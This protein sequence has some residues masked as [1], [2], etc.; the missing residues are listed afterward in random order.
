MRAWWAKSAIWITLLLALLV[1]DDCWADVSYVNTRTNV[2]TTAVNNIAIVPPV[3]SAAG[4]LLITHIAVRSSVTVTTPSGWSVLLGPTTN[5][6]ARYYVFYRFIP[7]GGLGS[8]TFTFSGNSRTVAGMIALRSADTVNP[9]SAFGVAS[10]TGTTATAPTRPVANDG[11]YVL[12]L[13]AGADGDTAFV[14]ASPSSSPAWSFNSTGGTANGIAG[15]ALYRAANTG[16]SG[17]TATSY[18]NNA[19]LAATL[20]ISPSSQVCFSDSFNRSSGLGSD[21]ATSSSNGSFGVPVI[22]NNR[23]RMTDASGNVATAATLQRLFPADGNFVQLSFLLHDYG[24]NGADGIAVI[25]SDATVTPQ[26]GGYGGS[27]GY[28]QLTATSK[29]GFA[30][31]WLGVGLDEYGNFL[32]TG[33]GRGNGSGTPAASC[34]NNSTLRPDSVSVRGSG[35]GLIGYRCLG[36]TNTLSPGVDGTPASGH[37]YRVTIDA[38]SDT[39]IPVTIERDT[40]GGTSYTT[41]LSIADVKNVANQTAIPN[42]FYLSLTGSTGGSNNIHEIDELSVCATDLNPVGVQIDHFRFLTDGQALTCNPE[43]ITIQAC[44]DSNCTTQYTGSTTVTLTPANTW[45]GGNPISFTG[46]STTLTLAQSTP[47][48]VALNVTASTPAL[49]PLATNRCYN[50][51]TQIACNLLFS[52]SGFLISAPNVTANK[53]SGLFNVSAVRKSDNGLLCVPAFQNVSRTLKFY[54]S[55][56]TPNTGTQTVALRPAAAGGFTTIATASPGTD[57]ALAFNNSGVAQMELKY[58]DAG[59][60]TLNASYTG[61]AGTGDSG[62]ALAGAGNFIS[63]PAGYCLRPM[64]LLSP[65][66]PYSASCNTIASCAVYQ[67]AGRSFP[68]QVQAMQWVS[69]SETDEAF[70]DNAVTPNFRTTDATTSYTLASTM[71][72]ASKISNGVLGVSAL[73]INSGGQTTIANQTLSEVGRFRVGVANTSSYLGVNVAALNANAASRSA[74]FGRFVPDAFV[75]TLDDTTSYLAACSGQFTYAGVTDGG[76]TTGKAGQPIPL[77]AS[78]RAIN[79]LSPAGTTLNYSGSVIDT[80]G[81]PV[82]YARLQGV[83]LPLTA[84]PAANGVFK[85]AATDT[86][87]FVNGISSNAL[88]TLQYLYNL[89]NTAANN[90]PVNIIATLTATDADS[91]TGTDSTVA[92][93]F[94]LGRMVLENA[95][96]PEQL[97]LPIPLRLEYFDGTRWQKN[98]LDSCTDYLKTRASL[99]AV[100]GGLNPA[101]TSINRPNSATTVVSGSAALTSTLQLSAP[102]DGSSGSIDIQYNAADL[103]GWLQFDWDNDGQQDDAPKARATFGRYRGSDRVIY[104]RE[105]LPVVP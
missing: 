42:D 73:A 61:S 38:R 88:T 91:T 48:T 50:G 95:Y 67:R 72:E 1:A 27:L 49:K 52:D 76:T 23:L 103:P 54:S 28:A 105:Q 62:V 33:E 32:N 65:T 58:P 68:L 96:G 92:R 59:Q 81:V 46:G 45:G 37:R 90:A 10:G 4:D 43:S 9:I 77:N 20:I 53:P 82:S 63:L 19:W 12:A 89:G 6:N 13:F 17:T 69:D 39:A 22:V 2:Q 26:P 34:N 47:G 85:L 7:T 79:A 36:A 5:G 44:L 75:V 84:T 56:A 86:Y 18:S 97:A 41:L 51:G 78:I 102:S 70:C 14:N 35:S 83:G 99:V 60:M 64:Q 87:N 71:V 29:N 3:N 16:S 31:G 98:S 66:T 104:W 40:T 80:A 94:R 55:Y 8:Q 93:A 101:V 24:G 100:S 57:I 15:A 25:L 30:G 74:V 21:W 11:S